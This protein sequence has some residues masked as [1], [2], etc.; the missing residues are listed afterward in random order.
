MNTAVIDLRVDPTTKVQAQQ[1]AEELGFSVSSLVNAF[2]K[3]LI[4][5]KT[6][7]FEVREEPS[8]WLIESLKESTE[9]IKAG[10]LSPSF[11]NADKAIAWLKNPKKRYARKI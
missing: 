6:V 9:D 5:T 2:L 10:R 7:L 3:N 8:A 4:R 1:I 11:E